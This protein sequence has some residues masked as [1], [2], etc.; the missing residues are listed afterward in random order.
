MSRNSEG[1]KPAPGPGGYEVELTEVTGEPVYHM[2]MPVRPGRDEKI[3]YGPAPDFTGKRTPRSKVPL[4]PTQEEIE[5]L[6]R[7]ARVAF[8]ARC[9]RRVLPAFKHF[10]PEAPEEHIV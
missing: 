4:V 1:K 5:K 8:A 2:P 7:W 6:P 9:A 10:W 3:R